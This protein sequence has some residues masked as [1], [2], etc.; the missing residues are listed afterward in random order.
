MSVGSNN[1]IPPRPALIADNKYIVCPEVSIY[2]PGP[3]TEN[4]L[5]VV[6]LSMLVIIEKGNVPYSASLPIFITPPTVLPIA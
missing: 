3:F 5:I 4:A 2:P 6:L 1:Q